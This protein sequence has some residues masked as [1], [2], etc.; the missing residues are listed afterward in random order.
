MKI[1]LV[2]PCS[3]ADLADEFF[4]DQRDRAR[5]LPGYRGVPVSELAKGLIKQ[6]HQVSIATL[7]YKSVTE[8]ASF[9][10]PSLEM[11]VHP[12]RPRARQFLID[13]YR[14]ERALL[15]MSVRDFKPDVV[16][17]HWTYE[18]ALGAMDTGLP[19]GVTAH[20]SPYTI[21]KYFKDAYRSARLL[22]AQQVAFRAQNLSAVSPYLGNRWRTQMHYRKPISII[23]NSV[24]TD[25]IPQVRSPSLHPTIISVGDP[26]RLKNIPALIK[27]FSIVRGAMPTAEL[28][29][30]GPGLGHLDEIASSTSRLGLQQGVTFVGSLNRRQVA[31]EYSTSWLV[32]HPS[33]EECCPMTLLEALGAGVPAIGGYRSGGVPY[34]LDHGRQGWLC[35]IR[36]PSALAISI[37]RMI[38]NG[39]PQQKEGAAEFLL[40]NFSMDAVTRRYEDW[41]RDIL[42]NC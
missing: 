12:G 31:Q 5:L 6:G 1:A 36:D 39:P 37:L 28:R 38:D 27:A 17:G 33:L 29:L 24:P 16:H 40:S 15:S 10:G 2:G 13:N 20:D 9:S 19:C 4:A 32:A 14:N 41:Y 42:R 21:V 30:I 18:F 11:V 8:S 34:V 22:I 26:S 7:A 23:P 25:A 3:P 35:D